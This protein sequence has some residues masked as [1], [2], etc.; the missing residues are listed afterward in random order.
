[1]HFLL[2]GHWELTV[3]ALL[4]LGIASLSDPV[5]HSGNIL[6]LLLELGRLTILIG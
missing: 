3:A 4:S 2:L 6:S 1:M 5:L